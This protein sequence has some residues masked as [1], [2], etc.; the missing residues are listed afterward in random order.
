MAKLQEL[1]VNNYKDIW[2]NVCFILSDHCSDHNLLMLLWLY[3]YSVA[4]LFYLLIHRKVVI[5]FILQVLMGDWSVWS[6]FSITMH[7]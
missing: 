6:C 5:R 3:Y 2:K 1:G 7:R 4:I